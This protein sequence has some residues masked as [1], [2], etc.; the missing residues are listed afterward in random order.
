MPIKPMSTRRQPIRESSRY[1]TKDYCDFMDI[2]RDI[3]KPTMTLE[4]L[5][6]QDVHYQG[7]NL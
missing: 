7:L 1:T 5:I 2:I 6:E 4:Q 3:Q